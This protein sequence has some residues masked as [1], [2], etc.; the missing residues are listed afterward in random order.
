MNLDTLKN[1]LPDFAKDIKLNLSSL[2]NQQDVDGLSAKQ[3]AG[4]ALASAYSTKQA[5]FISAI[6]DYAS[7]IL[8][9]ADIQGIKIATSLMAMNNIYYRFVH[10]AG[11]KSFA[12]MPAKLRMNGMANPGIDKVDFELYALAVSAI[13][14]CGMCMDAHVK[15]LVQHQVSHEAIQTCIRVSAVINAVAQVLNI[16]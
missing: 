6:L 2:L 13:N 11:D 10:L 8:T 14:G 1:H 9:E 16:L 12:T 3:I 15:S 7:T 4:I 5:E